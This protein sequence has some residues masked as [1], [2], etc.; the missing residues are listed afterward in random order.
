MSPRRLAY[1]VTVFLSAF[2]LFQVQ[3]I[4]AKRLLPWFGGV[5]AVWTTCMLFFQVLLLLGYA[6][7]H[8]ASAR[9][10]TG[11][12]RAVH[13][14]L[15][16]LSLLA[17]LARVAAGGPAVIPGLGS[18]PTDP[19]SPVRQILAILLGSVGLPYFVLSTTGPLLQTWYAASNAGRSPYRLYAWSNLG[20]LLA[21]VTYPFVVEPL[22]SLRAQGAVWAGGYIVFAAAVI[23]VAIREP[24]AAIDSATPAT[25]SKPVDGMKAPNASLRAL[26]LGLAAGPSIL[27]LAVTNQMCQEVAVIPLLWVLPLGLYLLSL[28]LCFESDRAYRR[29]PWSVALVLSAAG[30]SA[31]LAKGPSAGVPLQIAVLS[32]VLLSAAM[33]CHGELSRLKPGPRH[34]TSFYMAVA[35]GGAA[36]GIF[37]GL[38]APRLFRAF[39]ELPLG[40]WGCG[41]L[42]M[43][44]LARDK[45][46]AFHAGPVLPSAMGLMVLLLASPLVVGGGTGPILGVGAAV[47][48][49]ALLALA[50][51]AVPAG[52]LVRVCTAATWLLIGCDLLGQA[53][54]SV[55][56]ARWVTRNFY[57]TLRVDERKADV[58]GEA[59]FA[60][61]HG[62]VTHGLQYRSPALENEPTAY[63]GRASGVG[64]A[65]RA[66]RDR[67][68]GRPL[69]LAVVGLGIGTL[70]AYGEPRDEL[71]FYEI[72]PT[73]IELARGRGGF[74]RF[75]KDTAATVSIAPGDARISLEREGSP[76]DLDLLAVDAFNSDSIPVHL[77]T[78][79]A[80]E[81]Y[82]RHLRNPEGLLALHLSN[83][84]L[85]LRPVA[86]AL[87][88]DRGLAFGSISTTP[89]REL[90][91][92]SVWA[93]LTRDEALLST[94]A[95]REAMDRGPMAPGRLW[96]DDHSDLLRAL[97]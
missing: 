26:W 8:L 65:I 62:Q 40:L 82:L 28:V 24:R 3:F 69:R 88:R 23:L 89:A 52:T 73:V 83:R 32:A 74:F 37:V 38:V 25:A 14:A 16:A 50:R 29:S 70:A 2:L 36:G 1:P 67:A 17:V 68:P 45:A 20:S 33:V 5:P 51:R 9:L 81:V 46:S 48:A 54:A 6:Y 43:A 84:F 85:E 76:L 63:F 92:P 30:T 21:L 15:V 96:S 58:S 35:A 18:R 64:L 97:R 91:F 39:W 75:L 31:I 80:L 57:G 66:L 55:V 47:A 44:A 13:A 78:R 86:L 56:H 53:L 95:L 42:F 72:N 87:A 34:L 77:L 71:R 27:F 60:L 59:Y 22:L 41:L 94:P 61:K 11:K 79:E 93:L 4:A 12:R 7:A 19:G 10:G 90:E 49:V